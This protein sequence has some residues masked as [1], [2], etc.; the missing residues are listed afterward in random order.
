LSQATEFPPLT[1]HR[2][3]YRGITFPDT[4]A[5]IAR[6]M[7]SVNDH[8]E[9]LAAPSGTWNT[10]AFLAHLSNLKADMREV[11]ANFGTQTGELFACLAEEV[12]ALR[13]LPGRLAR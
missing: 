13:L 8:R 7:H 11:R 5:P 2:A 10:L 4:V 3:T 12:L 9:A 1:R 6:H